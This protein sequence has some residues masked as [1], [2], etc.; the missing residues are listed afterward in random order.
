MNGYEKEAKRGR[1]MKEKLKKER[2][3]ILQKKKRKE[4]NQQ[5]RTQSGESEK[6][7][8]MPASWKQSEAVWHLYGENCMETKEGMTGLY[9][10]QSEGSSQ[11]KMREVFRVANSYGTIAV[12]ANKK[13]E[14]MIVVSQKREHN[15]KTTEEYEKN[16]HVE[17]KRRTVSANGEFFINNNHSKNSAWA[18]KGKTKLSEKRVFDTIKMYNDKAESKMLE[19]RMPFL[20]LEKDKKNLVNLRKKMRERHEKGDKRNAQ[21]LGKQ[22]ETL[23]QEIQQKEQNER[24]VRKKIKFAWEKA[25]KTI[26]GDFEVRR[27]KREKEEKI[28]EGLSEIPNTGGNNPEKSQK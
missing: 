10:R 18:Y 28:K 7:R 26:T 13:K 17:R 24:L 14:G 12:G 2:N 15:E 25:Q 27:R 21:F 5:S 23:Q 6:E 20:Q 22:K 16:L 1:I 9:D 19:K 3:D 11:T 8:K 4:S